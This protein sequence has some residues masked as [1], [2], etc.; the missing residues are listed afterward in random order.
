MP[1]VRDVI[2]RDGTPL[3]LRTPT[4]EDYDAIKSFYEGLS[5]DSL[6]TRFHGWVRPEGPARSDAEADGDA[7][8]VLIGWRG[9]R[10]V[11]SGGY[12]RLREPAVAEVAFTVADD[13]QGRGVATRI[14]EQLAEIGAARGIVR[15][16]AEVAETNSAMLR[17][18]DRAGFGVR[19]RLDFEELLVSLD[20]HPTEAVR[21]LV[22]ERDHVGVVA[23]LRAI[24][25]PASVAVVGA[26][27]EPGSVGGDL[28][29]NLIAG[30]FRGLAVPV[31]GSEAAVRSVRAVASLADLEEPPQLVVVAVPGKEALDVAA[32]AARSGA[33]A[34]LVTAQL[35]EGTSPAPGAEQQLLEIVR[36]AGLRLVGPSSLGVVNNNEAVSLRATFAG[37]PVPAGH[38][39]ISSQSGAIGIALLGDAAARG[40]GV[41]SFVSLGDRADVSTNDL[42]EYW[43]EDE[44]TAAVMLYVENFGNPHHFGRIA[45]RV[46]RRKPILAIKGRRR[47]SRAAEARSHTAAA[48]R[49]EELVD[50]LLRNAGVMRFHSGEELF[51]TA[52]FFETQPLPLGRRVGIVSNSRGVAALATD[53]CG[54]RGLAVGR[55][56]AI[57]AR[58]RPA[59]YAASIRDLLAEQT[60]DAAMAYYI[61]VG[62]GDP[63]AV[64]GAISVV[65]AHQDKPVVVS[66]LGADGRRVQWTGSSVPNF[67]FP[68]TCAAVLSRAV[69]RRE[70]LSRALGQQP[71]FDGIDA[72][73]ARARVDDWLEPG[74]SQEESGGWLPTAECEALLDGYGIRCVASEYCSDVERAVSS[75]SEFGGSVVLKADFPPPAHAADVDAVLLG[76]EGENAVRAGWQEL[77]RRTRLAGRDWRGA[78]VQPLAASGADVLI[79]ALA[80]AELGQ[81]MAVGL[82]GRQAGL[83]RDVAYRLL[84]LTDVDANELI[85]A[86]EAISI[87]LR[88]FRGS[89][90]KDRVALQDLILRFAALLRAVPE[91]VE[92]DLN[93]VRSL[94]EGAVVLDVRMRLEGTSPADSVTRWS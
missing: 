69:E 14:L 23:S 53:A 34:L 6:Y 52:E 30:G 36:S 43:E 77:E 32:E 73:A 47:E 67:H 3:R 54:S 92:V 65:S 61:D 5:E 20:I 27:N 50:A 84:P 90:P 41:S 42:L 79:G 82:G 57:G 8:V 26:S 11:A 72:Q 38:L 49:D 12:D 18:F 70:W 83:G 91:L 17:V 75:A 9:D 37:A 94:P 21:E 56:L 81:V 28:F 87:Q 80:D 33:S 1:L 74:A 71:E 31:N 45:R 19:S 85:D 88:G 62:G 66:V 46:A 55:S 7:R 60:I 10:V 39:A 2:L 89:P 16:D 51:D 68:E 86:S 4:A 93:P 63:Q 64:L 22:E 76:L 25:A 44:T 13:F 15:F 40:L 24:L 58:A 35:S 48:L 59:D 29:V 78:I